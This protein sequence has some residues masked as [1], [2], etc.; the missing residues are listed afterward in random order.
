MSEIYPPPDFFRD[1]AHVGSLDAYR[2]LYDRSIAD[3]EAFWAEQAGQFHWF[4]PWD[5]VRE[6]NY[7]MNQ[8]PISI[9]WFIGG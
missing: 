8:G 6:Y 3:P 9:K 4:K 5:A 7:D 1:R 2:E